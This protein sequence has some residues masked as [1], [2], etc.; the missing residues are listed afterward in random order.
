[1]PEAPIHAFFQMTEIKTG[2]IPPSIERLFGE[3]KGFRLEMN[4][5]YEWTL[6]NAPFK[7]SNKFDMM[8]QKAC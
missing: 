8:V 3:K 5:Q 1:L 6:K 2:D 7:C 4:R